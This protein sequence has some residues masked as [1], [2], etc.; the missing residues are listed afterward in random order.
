MTKLTVGWIPEGVST[1]DNT[2]DSCR[3]LKE[4]DLPST[5]T[6]IESLFERPLSKLSTL[7]RLH[8]EQVFLRK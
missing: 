7:K 3:Q 8:A 2:F 5:I 4:I 6:K 1:L